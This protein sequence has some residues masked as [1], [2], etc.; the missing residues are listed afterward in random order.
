MTG[1]GV[2]RPKLA[3][4]SIVKST[5]VR[6]TLGVLAQESSHCSSHLAL[7]K[8]RGPT[9]LLSS[10][11]CFNFPFSPITSTTACHFW[12]RVVMSKNSNSMD[13]EAFP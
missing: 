6:V 7:F 2:P 10:C 8:H 13:H 1:C 9:P 3:V 11:M 5:M 4:Y 12:V